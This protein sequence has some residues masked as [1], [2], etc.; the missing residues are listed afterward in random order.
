[1][2]V[3][4]DPTLR[5]WRR[6]VAIFGIAGALLGTLLIVA[7]AVGTIVPPLPAV[8]EQLPARVP[9]LV[10]S[11]VLPITD[12]GTSDALAP[13]AQQAAPKAPIASP[14]V[15][16]LALGRPDE[17]L[18]TAFLTQADPRSVIDLREHLA[19]LDVVFPDWF[20]FDTA[21]G[22]LLEAI[23]PEVQALL[24]SGPAAVMPRVTNLDGDENWRPDIFRALVR[25]D[26]ARWELITRLLDRTKALHGHGV[27]IDIEGLADED[28]TAYL[29]WL[30]DLTAR[31]HAAG[32]YVTVDLPVRGDPYDFEAIGKVVDAVVVMA[33]DEHYAGGQAGP[34]ASRDWFNTTVDELTHRVPPEKL[35]VGLG[36][37]GYDWRV[38]ST[39][40]ARP[41]S[42]AESMSLANEF[43]AWVETDGTAVNST[44]AYT[45][46]DGGEHRVWFLDAV[47]AWNQLALV[48]EWGCRGVSLWRLGLEE[49]TVWRFFAG[50]EGVAPETLRRVG[51]WPGVFRAGDGPLLRVTG[52]PADGTRDLSF[53][54]GVID[55]AAYSALPTYFVVGNYGHQ[56]GKQIALTFD[57]GPDRTWTPQL[58]DVLRR[59][60]VQATFFVVGERA[61]QMPDL[62]RRE[63]TD[64]HLIGNHTFGHPNLLDSSDLSIRFELNRTQ[65]LIEA[66]TGL[67]TVLFRAPYN[68]DTAPTLPAELRPLYTV[69]RLGYLVAGSDIDS[70]DYTRP[71]SDAIVRR[72]LEGVAL[73]G[74]HVVTLHDAGGDRAQTVAAVDRLIPAL[75]AQ[76][77]TFVTLDTLL[78]L[79]RSAVMP[80]APPSERP[81]ALG[82]ELVARL[83]QWAWL[84]IGAL[85]VV[86]TAI[87]TIRL[88]SLLAVILRSRRGEQRPRAAFTGPVA[89]LVPAFNEGK[90]IQATLR[91]ILRSDY[92]HFRVLVIDDGSTDDTAARVREI[93][94][95][96]PR[97]EI[98]S[99]PNGGK[100]AALNLGFRLARE[101]VIVTVD[102][103]TVLPPKTVRHLVAP[104]VDP[105][106]DA[107]CGNV[108]VGNVGN[109]LTMSQDVEYVTSQSF[110]RRAF[111]ILNAVP[112]V[113]GATGAWRRRAVLAVGGYSGA[114]LTEDADLTVSVLANGGRIV[115][116][117]WATSITE[118]PA[119][120]RALFRQRFRWTYGAL[121]T[122]WK[123]RHRLGHGRVGWITLPHILVFQL[124]FPLVSPI[125]DLAALA[126]LVRG[127]YRTLA[128][129][130]LLF[131]SLD[132]VAA[133]AAFWFDG[134]PK[135][136]LWI[137]FIQRFYYRQFMYVVTYRA[138]QE[139]IR[140]RRHGWNKLDRHPSAAVSTANVPPHAPTWLGASPA[141]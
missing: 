89:V 139:A 29:E 88:L 30:S 83:R 131:T 50:Q 141:E 27:N 41:L 56:D 117:P 40:P 12:T 116:S 74:A 118:A 123:H 6:A 38:G 31:F 128:L 78:G 137:V 9:G 49:P 64:G 66:A 48:R 102:A 101:E 97:V 98:I 71:G 7:A 23:N 133:T 72:V 3:F 91:G 85:F 34:I 11:R 53:D 76:G 39:D 103:D 54:R 87:S 90:V 132:L 33:Y 135:R 59:H 4:E 96:D 86:A 51:A 114:T 122:V 69:T 125:G 130:Y 16:P 112:V 136:T 52:L 124:I 106:V 110:D 32:L 93:A 140:G 26:E 42:F 107:V 95:T 92:P 82:Q 1:M 28:A 19:D 8:S 100:H 84:A 58:L 57:D 109:L 47:S 5:R 17:F 73:S 75:K 81:L 68:T 115:F 104:F 79:P 35:I 62:V 25:D 45:D 37:Y 60:G 119:S 94:A 111:D 113:P 99:T 126:C 127:D 80:A 22:A 24:Q 13:G 14:F 21:D 61:G 10:A 121:Q 36:G 44:F 70:L 20:R 120:A 55:S 43:G 63:V 65:R 46:Y 134:H 2:M 138:V 67:Q 129:A 18:A 77:Y 108:Q 105:A 15:A